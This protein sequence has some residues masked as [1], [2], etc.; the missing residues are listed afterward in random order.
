VCGSAIAIFHS[1]PAT[2]HP[3]SGIQLSACT[4]SKIMQRIITTWDHADIKLENP[5]LSVP[6]VRHRH[7]STLCF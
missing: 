1:V 5:S 3:T 6:E 7:L 2:A 4:L